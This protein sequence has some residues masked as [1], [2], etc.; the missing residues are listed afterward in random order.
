MAL[1]LQAVAETMSSLLEIVIAYHIATRK[2]VIL[3]GDGLLPSLLLC[4]RLLTSIRNL[5]SYK[6]SS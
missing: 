2:P 5:D 1:A 4:N 6:Q 3:E